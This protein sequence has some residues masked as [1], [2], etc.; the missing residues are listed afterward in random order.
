MRGSVPGPAA[1]GGLLA[2]LR[3][4]P[5]ATVSIT[6]PI[7]TTARHPKEENKNGSGAKRAVLSYTENN[8]MDQMAKERRRMKRRRRQ[9]E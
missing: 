5:P 1:H 6:T 8:D 2:G 4:H 3:Q 7:N 9:K